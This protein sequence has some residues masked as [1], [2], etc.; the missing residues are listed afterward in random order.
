MDNPGEFI[1]CILSI[2]TKPKLDGEAEAIIGT[3][4]SIDLE[5][6]TITLDDAMCNGQCLDDGFVLKYGVHNIRHFKFQWQILPNWYSIASISALFLQ[7]ILDCR[8]GSLWK[9]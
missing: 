9:G 4:K 7:V 8:P 1:G 6:Q 5:N 3:V 2:K